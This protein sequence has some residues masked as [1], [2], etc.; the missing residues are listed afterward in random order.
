MNEMYIVITMDCER[1]RQDTNDQASGPSSWQESEASISGYCDIAR[2]HG[3]PVTLFLHPEVVC[4]HRDLLLD[5]E[6]SGTCIDGLHL[7]PWKFADGQYNTHLGRLDERSQIAVL[8]EAIAEYRCVLGRRPRY[9]RPGWFSANDS[10]YRVLVQLGFRGGSVSAPERIY[11]D[12]GA[13]WAS[14]PK[15]PHLPNGIFRN[16]RG[17]VPFGEMPLTCDFSRPFT[18]GNRRGF[19]D[20]RPDNLNAEHQQMVDSI[21]TQIISRQPVVPVINIVTHNEHDY[22]DPSDIVRQRYDKLLGYIIDGCC[23]RNIEP[24]GETIKTVIDLIFKRQDEL[25]ESG[26]PPL[27]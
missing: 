12:I 10:T 24:I 16:V 9:F 11:P 25:G 1:L 26:L 23:K 2:K 27:I 15:D 5:L 18:S 7:H 21:L 13:I 22:S 19:M 20:L 14:S 17:C 6:L 4:A 3:L 8:S